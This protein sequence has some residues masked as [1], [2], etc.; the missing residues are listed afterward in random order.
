MSNA[1]RDQNF[2]TTL[3]AVSSVDGVTP[4]LLWADPVTHRLLVDATG[5]GGGFTTLTA[6]GS[7][8]GINTVFTFT[9]STQ[10]SY[11]VSDGVWLTALDDNGGT[12]WTWSGSTATMVVPPNSSL[13]GVQ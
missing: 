2:V 8:N 5:G 1:K 7:R 11:I 13:F 3:L 10:P 6:T 9:T 4:V 12:Q